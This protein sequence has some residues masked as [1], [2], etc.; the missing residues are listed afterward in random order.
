MGENNLLTIIRDGGNNSLRIEG[1]S[2]VNNGIFVGEGTDF[3][4][5]H[6]TEL[7]E[8]LKE[9]GW[10]NEGFKIYYTNKTDSTQVQTTII[11]TYRYKL[12]SNSI[13]Y[14]VSENYIDSNLPVI[15][16]TPESKNSPDIIIN[17]SEFEQISSGVTNTFNE[18]FG[19]QKGERELKINRSTKNQIDIVES[20]KTIIPIDSSSTSIYTSTLDLNDSIH[21]AILPGLSAK[22]DVTF[23]YSTNDFIGGG[24]VTFS[25]FKYNEEKELIKENIVFDK[26]KVIIE[27]ING[28]IRIFPVSNDVNECILSDVVIT[29]GNLTK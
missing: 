22:V 14:T 3:R 2:L 24:D 25:A 17:R 29:Y 12:P 13:N 11:R 18:I 4:P 6:C 26:G 16:P 23:M 1:D 8:K 10:L 20:S 7:Q 9:K 5:I 19:D 21:H 15:N 28:I 27:Y